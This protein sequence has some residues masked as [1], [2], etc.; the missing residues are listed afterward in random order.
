MGWASTEGAARASAI[1]RLRNGSRTAGPRTACRTWRSRWPRHWREWQR[2]P[3]S[4]RPND[5]RF[6]GFQ[7]RYGYRSDWESDRVG[8]S[9]HGRVQTGGRVHFI[10]KKSTV[11]WTIT[12]DTNKT[13]TTRQVI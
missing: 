4:R 13:T 7:R 5:A 10:K 8:K 6:P 9:V 2:A 11:Q 1:I 3:A 12:S